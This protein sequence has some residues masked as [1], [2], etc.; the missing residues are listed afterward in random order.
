MTKL[1]NVLCVL[2]AGFWLAEPMS[3]VAAEQQK[4]SPKHR[5]E[6]NF[7]AEHEIGRRFQVSPADLPSPKTGSI[8]TNRSLTVPYGGQTLLVPAG[9]TATPFATGLS[10]TRL[11]VVIPKGD[12]L[13]AGHS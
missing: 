12:V 6:E 13:G 3:P 5:L 4:S 9:F 7:L 8:V 1:E 10:N 2:L 11:L